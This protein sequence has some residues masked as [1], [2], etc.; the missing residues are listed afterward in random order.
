VWQNG[1]AGF[2]VHLEVI[3]DGAGT[4]FVAYRRLKTV[5]AA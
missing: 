4:A 2:A 5:D 3:A 1:D